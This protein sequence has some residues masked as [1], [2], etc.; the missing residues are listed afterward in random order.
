MAKKVD[1]RLLWG[2]GAAGLLWLLSGK[3]STSSSPPP[4]ADVPPDDTDSAPFAERERLYGTMI[5]RAMRRAGYAPEVGLALAKNESSFR[6]R[7]VNNAGSDAERGG[8]WGLT[9]ITLETARG[10]GF[11]GAGEELLD[12]ARHMAWFVAVLDE[13]AARVGHDPRDLVSAWNSGRSYASLKAARDAAT[14]GS[15]TWSRLNTSLTSYVPKL[16]QSVNEYAARIARG[17]FGGPGVA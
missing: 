12:P 6:A 7:A 15:A 5:A 8:A 11:R 3:S 2:L 1:P 13:K 9:Q 10:V 4:P 16:M 17:E 14:P